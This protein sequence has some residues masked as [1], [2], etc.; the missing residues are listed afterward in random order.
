MRR[1]H[2]KHRLPAQVIRAGA[3]IVAVA[4][5]DAGIDGDSVADLQVRDAG[6]DRGDGAAG[7]VASTMGEAK[8]RSPMRPRCQ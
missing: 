7:F 1:R 3:A 8:T 2:R 6:P 5:G 4:A